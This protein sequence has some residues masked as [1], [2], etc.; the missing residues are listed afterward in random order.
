MHEAWRQSYKT[1][2][3]LNKTA[4]ILNSLAVHIL[5][6]DPKN[7]VANSKFN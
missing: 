1:K 2:Y 6:L 4:F 7:A 3:I 5:N